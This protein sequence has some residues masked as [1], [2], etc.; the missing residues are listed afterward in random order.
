MPTLTA[1]RRPCG[2]LDDVVAARASTADKTVNGLTMR[3]TP[4]TRRTSTRRAAL[5]HRPARRPPSPAPPPPARPR[6]GAPRRHR[7]RQERARTGLHAEAREDDQGQ[8]RGARLPD[9]P[10]GRLRHGLRL[11]P[12]RGARVRARPVRRVPEQPRDPPRRGRRAARRARRLRVLAVLGRLGRRARQPR[13]PGGSSFARRRSTRRCPTS[14]T[15]DELRRIVATSDGALAWTATRSARGGRLAVEVRRRMRGS[16]TRV[17]PARQRHRHR[18]RLAAQ[19]RPDAEL[20]E[21]RRAPHR[22]VLRRSPAVGCRSPHN[23]ARPT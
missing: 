9:G 22:D 18:S 13:A 11:P 4:P 1:A 14:A 15:F 20:D 7:R 8:P 3:L 5:A 17:D 12:Q 23:G 19:A 10:R 16:A 6:D 21:G 2:R